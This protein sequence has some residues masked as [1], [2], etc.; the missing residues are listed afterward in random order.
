ME[1]NMEQAHNDVKMRILMAAKKLFAEK[2]YDGTTVREI[3]EEAESNIALVSYYFGG[4][5]NVFFTLFDMFSPRKRIKLDEAMDDPVKGISY[6]I[7][8]MIDYVY[9][10]PLMISIVQQELFL[11]GPRMN[12]ISGYTSPVWLKLRELLENGREKG[13]FEFR[14]LDRA[15]IMIIA[16][17]ICPMK[18]P[19]MIDVCKEGNML[20]EEIKQDTL[21]FVLYG[22]RY[23]RNN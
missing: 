7:G 16:A 18:N 8:T 12:R 5:E 23:R 2:G 21:D 22:L 9:E 6:I 14:S 20:A 17:I 4:K 11:N 3:C 15:M 19:N 10:E 1:D 13:L